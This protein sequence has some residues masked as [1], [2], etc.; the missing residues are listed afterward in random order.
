M[1]MN[2][3]RTE[4]AEF[5]NYSYNSSYYLHVVFLVLLDSAAVVCPGLLV[6]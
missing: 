6:L 4:T 1:E 3:V 2:L 5:A